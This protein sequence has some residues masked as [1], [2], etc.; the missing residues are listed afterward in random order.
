MQPSIKLLGVTFDQEL[1]FKAHI[2]A[3]SRLAGLAMCNLIKLRRYLDQKS[4]LKIANALIL[5]HFDYCNSVLV[6]LP[7]STLYPFQRIQ[8]ITAKVIIGASKFSSSTEALKQLHMLPI[9]VRAEFKVLVMVYKCVHGLAP[10][11]LAE[12]LKEKPS[13]RATLA[14]SR[15]LL[16]IP[17]TKYSSFADRSFSVVGPTL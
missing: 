17:R 3:K 13:C 11:Y 10:S 6:N 8:N 2:A 16:E 14:G 9:R 7:K 12:L 5:S 4:C 15:A 1:S